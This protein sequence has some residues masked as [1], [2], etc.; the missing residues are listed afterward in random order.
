[1]IKNICIATLLAITVGCSTIPNSVVVNTCHT[2][3]L[4][5]PVAI[6]GALQYAVTKPEERV[7]IENQLYQVSLAVSQLTTQT[8]PISLADIEKAFSVDDPLVELMLRPVVT[9]VENGIA[10]LGSNTTTASQVIAIL[11]CVSA[12]VAN[13]TTPAAMDR[14]QR[15]GIVRFKLKK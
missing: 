3:D 6:D 1:M 13:A 5:I 7:I 11:Q 9:A 4:I 2:A 12:D 14:S 8:G 15:L 10:R